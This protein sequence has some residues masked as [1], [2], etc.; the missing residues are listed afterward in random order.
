ML[1]CF[2]RSS[3]QVP[4]QAAT[5]SLLLAGYGWTAEPRDGVK[6]YQQFCSICHGLEGQGI[7]NVFPPLA[8]AD[9]LV[10]QR[11]KALRAP[12]E[13]LAGKIEVNGHAFE[14][15]MPPVMLEDADLAAIFSHV[16]SSWGN[17]GNAPTAEEIASVRKKTKFPTLAAL[18]AAMGG[19][20]LPA[21]PEGW[22]LKVG[23]EL[24]F[25]PV[26]LAMHADGETV[27]ALSQQG[28]IWQ[29]KPGDSV[30]TKLFDGADY[31]D[32]NLGSEATLG[33]TVDREGRLYV[34][35]NQCNKKTT[36]V[37]NEVTIFRS[38]PWAKERPWA[39]P[40]PWFRT[41]YPFGVGPYNHGVSHIAQGP[42]GL[43][44]VNSGSRTDGGEAGKQ[45]NYST[46]G[47]TSLTACLWRLDP[48]EANPK[49]E[50]FANGLR[51]TYGFC[52]DDEGR[53]IGTE[54]GPD[55]HAPEELNVI[56]KG[57]HHGFP[58]QFSDWENKAYAHTPDAPKG[59]KF[60]HPLRNTGPDGGAAKENISTFDAHSCPSGIVW[61]GADWPAPLGGS[62]LTVR[63]G[64]LLKLETGD[65]GFDLLQMKPDFQKGTVTVKQVLAPWSRPI[66]LLAMA[67]HRVVIAEYCRGANLAAGLGTPGR[68]LVLQPKAATP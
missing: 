10:K 17:S 36:P 50:V 60:V 31:I 19:G 34:T 14:G 57:E 2:F 26:R 62:F 68:L 7:P 24:S 52:W 32:R 65:A 51:N 59:L 63:F 41:T 38:E 12:L 20:V 58:F 33:M 67:G 35:S 46:E 15:A 21:A 1:S 55:A 40:K 22:E 56:Q 5:A 43:M 25:S 64:N 30:A 28:D 45:P 37:A 6:L 16:Y 42:D 39:A 3:F 44:Y 23:V 48:R 18:K 29:W 66:D 54:N 53:L 27:L 61:L 4:L 9:F 49:L 47:E 11:E 13:G 8:K